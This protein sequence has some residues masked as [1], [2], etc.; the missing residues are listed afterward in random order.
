MRDRRHHELMQPA[1]IAPGH[2]T[3]HQ[4][5]NAL[6]ITLGGIR[7]LVRRNQLHKAGGTDRQPYY[8]ID[9]ITAL[10]SQRGRHQRPLTRRSTTCNDLSAELCQQ[11]A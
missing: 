6:G 3:A 5:A 7:Q 4:A 8:P 9:E 11:P 1:Y 10:I 2:L